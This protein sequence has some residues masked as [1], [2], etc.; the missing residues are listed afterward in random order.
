M[1]VLPTAPNVL[2]TPNEMNNVLKITLLI[3]PFSFICRSTSS[4][5]NSMIANSFPVLMVL[6]CFETD[7]TFF[8]SSNVDF[9]E[10]NIFDEFG[11]LRPLKLSSRSHCG[12]TLY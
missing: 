12:L 2:T 10:L 7:V 6:S 4:Q 1:P 8:N 5:K 3:R 11:F 9:I